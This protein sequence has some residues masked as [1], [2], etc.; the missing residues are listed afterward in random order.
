MSSLTIDIASL[1]WTILSV[2]RSGFSL[3]PDLA[4]PVPE[5]TPKE[6]HTACKMVHGSVFDLPAGL[7]E[8][9]PR[10]QPT[11]GSASLVSIDGLRL[12]GHLLF[13]EHVQSH[14]RV[15][16]HLLRVEGAQVSTES[17]RLNEEA[18]SILAPRVSCSI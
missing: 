15:A 18:L 1:A 4:F 12:C 13:F 7:G 11:Y 6:Q 10:N 8:Q 5:R 2:S 16:S 17:S 9:A 14:V 3:F